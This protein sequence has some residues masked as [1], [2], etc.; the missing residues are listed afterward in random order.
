[1]KISIARLKQ[2][3]KEESQALALEEQDDTPIVENLGPVELRKMINK[4]GPRDLKGYGK[5]KRGTDQISYETWVKARRALAKGQGAKEVAEIIK[6]EAPSAVNAMQVAGQ[7]IK[8]ADA[9]HGAVRGKKASL[10]KLKASLE[11][12]MKAPQNDRTKKRIERI[13]RMIAKKPGVE[14]Y[15]ATL[16]GLE[17]KPEET[18]ALAPQGSYSEDPPAGGRSIGQSLAPEDEESG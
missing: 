18:S 15:L 16:Q 1:M 14:E 13:K 7:G 2:I 10:E 4:L 5:N 8:A 6:A 11:K 17:R 12:A 3:I 9:A